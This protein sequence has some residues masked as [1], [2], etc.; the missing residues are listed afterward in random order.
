MYKFQN[1]S[2]HFRIPYTHVEYKINHFN[3]LTT[4]T[5]FEETW[6]SKLYNVKNPDVIFSPDITVI[7]VTRT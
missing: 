4:N 3:P 2:V 5:T 1:A 7:I 6:E